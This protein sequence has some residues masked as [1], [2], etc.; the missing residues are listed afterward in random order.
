MTGDILPDQGYIYIYIYMY[1]YV[2]YQFS[3]K[4]AYFCST[5]RFRWPTA[6]LLLAPAEGWGTLWV[7]RLIWTL[8]RGPWPPLPLPNRPLG[9]VILSE[10]RKT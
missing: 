1:G 2:L 7:P 9:G 6:T 5:R 8:H 3:P 4:K 10:I